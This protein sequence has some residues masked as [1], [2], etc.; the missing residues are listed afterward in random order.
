MNTTACRLAVNAAT[1]STFETHKVGACVTRGGAIMGVGANQERTH[2]APSKWDRRGMIDKLHAEM[3]CLLYC[4]GDVSGGTLYIARKTIRGVGMARPCN[5]C[6][7]LIRNLGIKKIVYTTN[8]CE[9][10][11][12]AERV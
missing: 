2:P 8:D 12:F 10:P 9:N 6:M 11:W 5:A 3:H 4:R 7:V 1:L